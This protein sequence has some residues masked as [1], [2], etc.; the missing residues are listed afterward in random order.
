VLDN[1]KCFNIYHKETII[2]TSC[3]QTFSSNLD[4]ST[5]LTIS[6]QSDLN[7][8]ICEPIDCYKPDK[9]CCD[10]PVIYKQIVRSSIPQILVLLLNKYME[11]INITLPRIIQFKLHTY[12]RVAIIDHH[13]DQN[14]GH[15]IA[16]VLRRNG[17]FLANDATTQEID[18]IVINKNTYMVFYHIS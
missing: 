13:G 17:T 18:D 3:Y 15:Y 16:Q 14:S 8:V 12:I 7:D 10:Q 11:K 6:T 1:K 2:C 9:K 5:Y 4:T